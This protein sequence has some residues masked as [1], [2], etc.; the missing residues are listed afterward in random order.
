MA[1][2]KDSKGKRLDAFEIAPIAG[3]RFMPIGDSITY[4]DAGNLS[5]NPLVAVTDAYSNGSRSTGMFAWANAMLGH[6]L[7]MVGN[8][9]VP[10]NTSE[11][12]L[13]RLD[14]LLEVPSDIV[15]VLAGANDFSQSFSAAQTIGNLSAI[16]SKVRASGRRLLVLTTMSR[17][18]MNNAGGYEYLSTVNRWIKNYAR[19]TPGVLL[20]DI[21]SAM[22]D[23]ATGTPINSGGF[24][25]ADGTHPNAIGAQAMGRVIAEALR[26][27]IPA[28]DIFS[29]S[30][31]DPLNMMRNPCNL[32]TTGTVANGITGTAGS[33][34]A[35]TAEGTAV[36]TASKLA[37]T[38]GMPGEWTRIKIGSENTAPIIATGS[39]L[40][41]NGT[42]AV[43]D[44]ITVAVEVR[45]SG[46]A[47]VSNF[48][49]GSFNPNSQA[50]ALA[51]LWQQG[52]GAVMDG[53]YVFMVQ[54]HVIRAGTSYIQARVAITAT[55][56][57]LDIGRCAMFKA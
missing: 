42:L 55:G 3:S 25:T 16:Y 57:T 40:F 29:T 15:S 21:C 33:F 46:L 37:R 49:G 52:S 18:T 24:Y 11:Q 27:I 54:G 13:A 4:L 36:A 9:G 10:G 20:A 12:I 14:K 34:W 19:N 1:Y 28:T 7:N 2:M 23:P 50:A 41:G 44:R 53:S 6:R 26:P 43:G 56:G 51:G 8:G 22:T 17:A 5:D 32:G 47:G 31:M 45:T 38:D 39:C 30:N 35:L 48:Y